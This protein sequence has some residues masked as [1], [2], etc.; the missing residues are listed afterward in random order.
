MYSK[1]SFLS[2][3][4]EVISKDNV[5]AGKIENTKHLCSVLDIQRHLLDIF[6]TTTYRNRVPSASASSTYN[7]EWA[8]PLTAQ[9]ITRCLSTFLCYS[10]IPM[11]TTSK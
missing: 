1:I 9:S 11:S 6:G 10:S 7:S 3:F 4:N 8:F 5:N 2:I